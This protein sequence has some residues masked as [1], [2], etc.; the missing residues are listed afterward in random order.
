L[1]ATEDE[2]MGL[3][4]SG[5]PS[6]PFDAI[7]DSEGNLIASGV[8]L[9]LVLPIGSYTLPMTLIFYFGSCIYEVNAP[10]S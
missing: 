2:S 8:T 5:S 9:P 10:T 7:F 3:V 6:G 4:L 1:T